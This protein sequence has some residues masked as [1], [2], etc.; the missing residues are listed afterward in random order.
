METIKIIVTL[1]GGGACGA[2]ITFFLNYRKQKKQKI[3]YHVFVYG[4]LPRNLRVQ[5]YAIEHNLVN[6][7][8]GE[9]EIL[10]NLYTLSLSIINTGNIDYKKFL[11]SVSLPKD[12]QII[13]IEQ[14]S[15]ERLYESSFDP[16]PGAS[17]G[18]N[19]ID[20]TVDPF[21]RQDER[22]YTIL[23]KAN[24]DYD[25][26]DRVTLSQTILVTSKEP[27]TFNTKTF[28]AR[29]YSK[30]IKIERILFITLGFMVGVVISFKEIEALVGKLIHLFS[31]P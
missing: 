8:T 1:I 24:K 23:F 9:K 30:K 22:D 29:H 11:F 2:L 13:T 20:I 7:K 21:N 10:S 27:V 19:Y 26:E 18:K 25:Y 3:Y 12:A 15:K 4:V 17:D 31:K 6:S 14:H 5:D 28:S 16:T